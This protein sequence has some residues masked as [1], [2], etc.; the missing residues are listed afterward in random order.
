MDK[1]L[2]VKKKFKLINLV[3]IKEELKSI[4]LVSEKVDSGSVKEKVSF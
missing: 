4:L 3:E 1:E 2:F